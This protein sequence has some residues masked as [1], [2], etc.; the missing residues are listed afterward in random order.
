MRNDERNVI[1]FKEIFS[2]IFRRL[3]LIILFALCGGIIAFCVSKYI[4]TPRY[5]AHLNLYVQSSAALSNKGNDKSDNK[6]DVNNLKQLTNTY[7]EVLNDDLVMHDIGSELVKRFGE[8]IMKNVFVLDKD[9]NI[10]ADELRSSIFIESVPDTLVLK[11][12]VIT[13]DPE[14]SVAICNYFA[15]YSDQYLQK[16]IGSDCIAKYMTWAKYNDDPVSPNKVKNT[17]LGI[18]AGILLSL[19]IIFLID[20]FDDSVRN[21]N[22]LSNR[23]DTAVIGEVGHFKSK[24]KS[25][26]RKS[27]FV[28]LFNKYV[29][30]TVVENY[31]AIRTSIIYSLSSYENKV[32]SVSSAEPF[33]GKSITAANIAITLA[34]GGNK[35]LLID[36]D[37][38]YP[39]QHEIFR[40]SE[41][42]GLSNALT[43]IS[44]LDKCIKKTFMEKLDIIS[45]GDAVANPS[46]LVASENMDKIIEKLEEK[47]T[48]III[49]TPAVNFFTDAVEIA[50][51]VSGMIMVVRHN[52]TSSS[53][54]DSAMSRIEFFEANMLGFIINDVKSNKKYNK[55]TASNRSIAPLKKMTDAQKISKNNSASSKNRSTGNNKAKR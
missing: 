42:K 44:D 28:S 49:D 26:D 40:I 8:P 12:K 50:K 22:T 21:V 43:D 18:V 39:V 1:N 34:Q 45:A 51:K 19:L 46:E 10:D 54:I 23:Y 36:A 32:I 17:A 48:Y 38:R 13:K 55:V 37:L 31:K 2:L 30:F 4:I 6:N 15:V 3:W 35:V 41:K 16:A 14:V 7:I 52:E 5:E 9:N 20:F 33:E 24:F 11:L 47:Y 25:G 27:R 29:P 53:D